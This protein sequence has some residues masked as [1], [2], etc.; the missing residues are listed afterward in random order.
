M[1][2]R[3]PI[4]RGEDGDEPYAN[5]IPVVEALVANGN[6]VL[7][8]GTPFYMDRDGWRCDLAAPIDFEF[9]DEHFEFPPSIELSPVHGTILDR[10]TWVVIEGP[11]E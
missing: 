8:P 4:E 10:D 1:S 2:S 9:V 11:D 7:D 6:E 5:L 3:T